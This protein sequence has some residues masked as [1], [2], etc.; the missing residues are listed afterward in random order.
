MLKKLSERS[1]LKQNSEGRIVMIWWLKAFDGSSLRVSDT[2][3]SMMD[4]V[5]VSP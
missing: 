2:V 3:T 4:V 5:Q 1:K